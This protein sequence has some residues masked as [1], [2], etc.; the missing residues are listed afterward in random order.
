MQS[1]YDRIIAELYEQASDIVR[2]QNIDPDELVDLAMNIVDLE[3]QHGV[4]TV[5]RINQRVDEL[6]R[7]IADRN[8][9]GS[10]A[11]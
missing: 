2:S 11:S 8:S 4:R 1:N 7:Q 3:D 6:I 10:R 5:R 9:P